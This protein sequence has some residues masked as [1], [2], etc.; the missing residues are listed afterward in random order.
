MTWMTV[1]EVCKRLGISRSTWDKWHATG[2]A[3]RAK[4]LPNGSLRIREDWLV[5]WIDD[6][7]EAA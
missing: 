3:P 1:A 7:P 2:R 5:T 4:K 6:L